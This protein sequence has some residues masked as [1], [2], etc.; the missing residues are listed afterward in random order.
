[1]RF[2]D[3]VKIEV[4][5]WKG[6]NWCVSGRREKYVAFG[7]PDGWDGW[8]WGSVFFVWDKN[9]NT[10]Q[11]LHYKKTIKAKNWEHWKGSSMNWKDADDVFV[12]VPLW[13]VIKEADTDQILW[14]ITQD[15]QKILAVKWG[16]WWWWNTHFATSSKQFP[17]FAMLWEPWEKKQIE[18]ELQLLS[19]IVLIWFP[20]V[21]K[22]SIINTISNTK[23]KVADYHFTTLIPNLWVVKYKNKDF[24]V[25]DMPWL[26]QN[27]SAWKWLWNQFLRHILKS[28]IWTFVIDI[29]RYE[30]G[31]EELKILKKEIENYI[32]SRFS[33]TH[34]DYKLENWFIK[35]VLHKND[36]IIFE[37]IILFL[38]NKTDLVDDEEI[39]E[40][41]NKLLQKNIKKL[42]QANKYSY[43]FYVHSGNKKKFIPFLDTVI[44]IWTNKNVYTQP[45]N[46]QPKTEK[47]YIKD[48][49]DTELDKLIQEWYLQEEDSYRKVWEVYDRQIAYY[50]FITMWNNQE[51]VNYFWEIM[52][53]LWK[54]NR[55]EKNNVQINDVLKIK[56]PYS[57][58]NDLYIE[59]KL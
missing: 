16:T 19:D 4:I 20:S 47:Q 55:L 29:S 58:Q 33:N 51:A 11:H 27:A 31:I 46:T 3:K 49:T 53:K 45:T 21:W 34:I 26:I 18:L 56:S 14:T 32:L 12:P 37:K 8:K 24:T 17:N 44:S 40:E 22:S 7:W 30:K 13:T 23:A 2:F 9:L 39:I 35:L 59:Y 50:A 6:W 15:W 38:V 28:A 48:I 25:A 1:M 41:F 42:F 57:W 36:D 54:I 52:Q 43:I 5:S 10:L